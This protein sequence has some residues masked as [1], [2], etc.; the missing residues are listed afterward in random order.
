MWKKHDTLRNRFLCLHCSSEKYIRHR[1][2]L[3]M[4]KGDSLGRY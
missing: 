2:E 4:L 1:N 3:K